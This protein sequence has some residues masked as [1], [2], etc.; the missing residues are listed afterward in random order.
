M[1]VVHKVVHG[2]KCTLI[3]PVYVDDLLP[4]GD[5]VLTN[6]FEH[7]IH[8]YFEVTTPTDATYFLGLWLHHDRTTEYPWLTLDQHQFIKLILS[9]F[10]DIGSTKATT[11]LSSS[12]RTLPNEEPKENNNPNFIQV[13]QSK[14]GSLMYLMLGTR[15]DIAY[16]VGVLGRFLFNPSQDHMDAINQL[17]RYVDYISDLCLVYTKQNGGKV[18]DP[19]GYV[20]S[21][22]A[23][24]PTKSR[25]TRSYS[26]HLANAVFSWSSKLLP[27]ITSS[28]AEAEYMSLFNGGQQAAWLQNFYKELGL[29]LDSPITIYCDSQPAISILKNEG[30]HT[31]SKHFKL[32]YHITREWVDR[33]EINV[34][35]V[36]TSSNIVDVL[37][38]GP[39]APSTSAST[40][41][42]G[43]QTLVSVLNPRDQT[44][45]YLDAPDD[46]MTKEDFTA[47]VYGD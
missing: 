44:S 46:R 47:L 11:P 24:E 4:I 15:P 25:S 10:T 34:E 35:Y 23:R 12:F 9:R 7:W 28:T 45:F 27:T 30:D 41:A 6:N 22:L 19:T 43:L 32:K 26:F 2:V 38:K 3:L 29:P 14:L 8:D 13:Y 40:E 42:L 5:K 36:K 39:S 37:T 18:I 17:F 33:K 1:F 21:N 31:H 16:T 20:D